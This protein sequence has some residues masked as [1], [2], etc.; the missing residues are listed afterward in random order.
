MNKTVQVLTHLH[1]IK[2]TEH[3]KE[4]KKKLRRYQYAVEVYAAH[5]KMK[6]LQLFRNSEI[7][8]ILFVFET[9]FMYFLI[10]KLVLLY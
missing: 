7:A 4:E 3:C 5:E 10:S 1:H 9:S 6:K 8:C 2:Q